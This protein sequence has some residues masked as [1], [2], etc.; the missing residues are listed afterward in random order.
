[1][2]LAVAPLAALFVLVAA[3][4][5][6][7]DDEAASD[8][9]AVEGVPWVLVSGVDVDGWEESAPSIS[10]GEDGAASG[11]SGCNQWGGSYTFDGDTLELGE[12]A[13]TSMGCPPPAD[14]VERAYMDALQ[15]ANRWRLEDE[16]LV[17][18]DDD[19]E[20]LRYGAASPVG[21]WQATGLLQGDAFT[22]LLAGTEITASF[23]EDGALSGSAGCNTYNSTYTT[24]GGTIEIAEPSST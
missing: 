11:S 9:S 23:D 22:S 19:A 10:F 12:I 16:E 20:L 3:G 1:M 18:L 2:R 7:G 4:G 17:L 13:M 14:E 21:D 8:P 6:G 15:Q 5:C 24:D